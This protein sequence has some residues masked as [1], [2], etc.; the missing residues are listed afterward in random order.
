MGKKERDTTQRKE[1]ERKEGSDKQ[2]EDLHTDSLVKD[3]GIPRAGQRREEAQVEVVPG[4]EHQRALPVVSVCIL[5]G[6]GLDLG[7]V[8]SLARVVPCAYICL[9]YAFLS[10]AGH[11]A[12]SLSHRRKK[13]AIHSSISS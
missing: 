1:K 12:V 3:H 6:R 8:G 4:V 10:R 5:D 9:F 2:I 11:R 13:P 7:D